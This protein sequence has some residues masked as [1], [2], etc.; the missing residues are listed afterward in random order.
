MIH[1]RIYAHI[2][3]YVNIYIYIHTYIYSSQWY[4]YIHTYIYQY[5][6]YIYVYIYII[7]IPFRIR[8]FSDPTQHLSFEHIQ[9]KLIKIQVLLISQVN[10]VK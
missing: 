10:E 6:Y 2:Y 1:K 5:T 4:I 9:P 8:L 7:H 3:M